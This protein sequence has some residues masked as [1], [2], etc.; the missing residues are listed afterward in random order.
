[1]A[2][3]DYLKS[4]APRIDQQIEAVLP[5]KITQEWLAAVVGAPT[6]TYDIDTVKKAVVEPIWDFLDRGG[7][8]WRPALMVICCEAVGGKAKDAMPFAALPELIH[9]GTIMVDDVEDSADMRRGKPATH[10]IYGVDLA[11]NTAT[12][13]YYLPLCILYRNL[14]KINAE[15]RLAIYDLYA[16]EMSRLS[17]GQAMDIYWHKGAAAKVSEEQ[18]LQMCSYK[19]GCLARFSAELGAILGNGSQEQRKKLGNFA[20]VLGV[21]FQIQD[22]ILNLVSSQELG[23]PYGEDITEGKRTIMVIRAMNTTKKADSEKLLGILNSH[24]R[25]KLQIS[26]A[27]EILRSSG[28]IDYAKLRAKEL[29]QAAWNELKPA[30]PQSNAKGLLKEFADFV[31][32]RKL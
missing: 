3:A 10:K 29:M 8:R 17:F 12:L 6:Y 13:M 22:D 11:I 14:Q 26:E 16:T 28:S 1:M 19:T 20:R 31:I 24:S 9:N 18:Y 7:K 5:R 21:A 30:L 32:E 15:A 2:I 25:D 23:K 27:I 4:M